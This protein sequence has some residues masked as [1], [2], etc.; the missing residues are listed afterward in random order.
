V[1]ENQKAM[2]MI[3]PTAITKDKTRVYEHCSL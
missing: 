2:Q 1:T 3:H